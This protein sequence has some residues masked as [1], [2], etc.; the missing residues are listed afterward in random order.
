MPPSGYDSK[1]LS[2]RGPGDSHGDAQARSAALTVD[3]TPWNR[4]SLTPMTATATHR[5][6]SMEPSPSA[7]SLTRLLAELDGRDDPKH[8]DVSVSHE[9]GWTLSAFCSGRVVFENVE[10]DSVAPQHMYKVPRSDALALFERLINGDVEAV[11]QQQWKDGYGSAEAAV[12][13]WCQ[14]TETG[15]LRRHVGRSRHA[16]PGDLSKR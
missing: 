13:R 12:D 2:S 9:S 5:D 1:M 6:G 8:G 16:D 4:Q 10:D 14:R 7:E 3:A 11:A 15:I